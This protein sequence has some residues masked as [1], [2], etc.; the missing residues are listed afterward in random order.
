MIA[1]ADVTAAKVA[2]T[3]GLRSVVRHARDSIPL[4]RASEA[5]GPLV[6]IQALLDAGADSKH[7]RQA[8]H[9]LTTLSS[10]TAENT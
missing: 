2:L 8:A 4:M 7:G 6:L 5:Q 10:A 3:H 1:L 9:G